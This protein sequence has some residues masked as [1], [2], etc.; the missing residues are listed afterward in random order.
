MRNR[1]TLEEL[2]RL[3]RNA[4]DPAAIERLITLIENEQG[5]PLYAAVGQLKRALSNETSAQFQFNG[6]GL[7]IAVEVERAAFE[8]WIA[9][10]LSR[11]E[12]AL[13]HALTR[14]G[15][16]AEQIDR[17]FLTGGSSLI[18]AVR[19]LFDRRF[20][21]DRIASGGELT[22]IAHGLARI[23]ALPEPARWAA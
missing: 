11:I 6:G 14:A 10:D 19:R 12:Q 15:I 13:D 20:G 5:Y 16:A 22:S 21:T 23:G 1:R 7:E 17:V 2:R 4:V 9:P 8:E 3:Q 18:P